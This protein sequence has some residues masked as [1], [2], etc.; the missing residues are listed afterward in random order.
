MNPTQKNLKDALTAILL[1]YS[2]STMNGDR[3]FVKHFSLTDSVETDYYYDSA[4]SE[5]IEQGVF[6]EEEKLNFLIENELWSTENEASIKKLRAEIEMLEKRAA[7]S[8]I[9]SETKKVTDKITENKTVLSKLLIERLNLVGSTA[10][11]LANQRSENFYI[12][13]SIF[14]DKD[15]E[16]HAFSAS[17][18][19]I[20]SEE[21]EMARTTYTNALQF[22]LNRN[23]RKIALS[24][25]FMDLMFLATDPFQILNKAYCYYTF[26]QVDLLNLGRYY[27][28][29]LSQDPA[30]PEGLRHD[31]DKL[32]EWFSST[33][34]AQKLKQKLS[35]DD[36]GGGGTW[37]GATTEDLKEAFGDDV[38]N[39]TTEIKK[40]A[41]QS[42]RVSMKDMMK[43]H[44]IK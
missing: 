14:K 12:Y 18:D 19:D 5:A 3:V 27:K 28:A 13:S 1:G 21:L 7:A 6:T 11:S 41:G 33:T 20:S 36:L 30:P 44:G 42:G 26:F 31:P 40:V 34:K 25:E 16:K 24:K 43:I 29:I 15:F 10:E 4:Y 2:V 35:K 39:M 9:K 32:E 38:K 37:V 17:F 22:I 23:I 8:I